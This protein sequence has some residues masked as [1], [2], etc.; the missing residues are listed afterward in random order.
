M[1]ERNPAYAQRRRRR[2]LTVTGVI[3]GLGIA[4]FVASQVP[5]YLIRHGEA[6][7][8]ARD[9][10]LTGPPCP[11]LTAEAFAAQGL[12]APKA[13]EYGDVVMAR[14]FGHVSCVKLKGKDGVEYPVCQFTSPATLKVTTARGEAYFAPGVGH[15]ATV[16]TEGG[17]ARCVIAGNFSLHP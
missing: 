4:A 9:W 14:Q 6:A 2:Q 13:F 15:P 16:S 10:T 17:V 11:S 8:L 12:K 1:I 5:G 7:Q 3:I